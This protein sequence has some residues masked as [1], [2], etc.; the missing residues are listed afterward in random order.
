MEVVGP[1]GNR[2]A[3]G[4]DADLKGCVYSNDR[5][6]LNPLDSGAVLSDFECAEPASVLSPRGGRRRVQSTPPA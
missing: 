2:D 4:A 3:Q 5:P 1:L 6:T